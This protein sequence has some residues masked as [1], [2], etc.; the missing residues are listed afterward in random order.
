LIDIRQLILQHRA[1]VH[2]L[3]NIFRLHRLDGHTH[4]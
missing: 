3:T 4:S 1:P 2:E